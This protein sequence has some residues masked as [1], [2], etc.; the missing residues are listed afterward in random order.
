MRGDAG[1]ASAGDQCHL[2]IAV[3]FGRRKTDQVGHLTFTT[4]RLQF[5]G[6]VDFTIA[7]SEVCRVDRLGADLIVFLQGTQRTLR[8][9][10]QNDEDARRA[11]V[12]AMHL[13]ALAQSHPYEPA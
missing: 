7:W 12:S 3:R 9:S 4:A 10:C 6:T 5:R 2:A 1:D 8:F 11:S 13:A